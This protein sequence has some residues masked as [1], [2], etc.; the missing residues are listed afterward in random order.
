MNAAQMEDLGHVSKFALTPMDHLIAVVKAVIILWDQ[1][2]LVWMYK[3]APD[4]C[5]K[6]ICFVLEPCQLT[7]IDSTVY[8]SQYCTHKHDKQMVF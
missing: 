4:W 3:I 7:V 5:T 2:A 6:H 1:I 8:S